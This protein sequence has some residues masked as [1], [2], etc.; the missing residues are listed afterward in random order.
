[1]ADAAS[2]SGTPLT[3]PLKPRTNPDDDTAKGSDRDTIKARNEDLRLA[4]EDPEPGKNVMRPVEKREAGS[5]Q[6]L[7]GA[8]RSDLKSPS[9]T[10]ASRTGESRKGDSAK[11][12]SAKAKSG[13]SL[14][15]GSSTKNK[16]A[17]ATDT[18][19]SGS[20]SVVRKGATPPGE[21]AKIQLAPLP[22][23]MSLAGKLPASSGSVPVLNL[24]GQNKE[25]EQ[26]SKQLKLGLI[27]GGAVLA[28]AALI[29]IVAMVM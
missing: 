15:A 6:V 24:P 29:G 3:P 8:E 9:K 27:I 2:N 22:P 19:A 10:G 26:K 14:K 23:G 25:A 1:M 28:V 13:T 5:S 11:G 20:S 12:D 7:H 17:P 4:P 16:V 21:T 18:P